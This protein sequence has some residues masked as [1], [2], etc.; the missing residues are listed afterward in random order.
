[1]R[2][3]APL[4]VQVP[5]SERDTPGWVKVGV[6]AAVGFVVGVA[7]P[8]VMGVRLGPR[9]QSNEAVASGAG[10]S[11]SAAPAVTVASNK[12]PT[13]A[14]T[15]VPS[16]AAAASPAAVVNKNVVDGDSTPPASSIRAQR[17][18]VLSCRTSDGVVKK[19]TRECGSVSGLDA[20]VSP[21]LSKLSECSG[22]RGQ[23]GKL[24]LV[25]SAD[26]SSEKLSWE[27]GKST[28]VGN[29]DGLRSCL[30][31]LFRGARLSG[32][33]HEHTRYTVAYASM[34]GE[35][36]DASAPTSTREREETSKPAATSEP[37]KGE[38]KIGLDTATVRDAPRTGQIV[39]RLPR[40]TK[41][42]IGS[43]KDGWYSIQYG[44]GFSQDGWVH[45]G[46]IAR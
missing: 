10:T 11:S 40:G 5:S 13:Q 1:M 27:I 36:G 38:L 43:S 4:T 46:A 20:Y 39:A 31:T 34:L 9:A 19:G 17:S 6:I 44:D 37:G 22:A 3:G 21:R 15:A 12:S 41:V 14:P 33:P 42:K 24:S 30:D 35:G 32:V 29:V 7:W 23:T 28:N 2:K 45:R 25:V 18:A 26:F 8:R 16:N